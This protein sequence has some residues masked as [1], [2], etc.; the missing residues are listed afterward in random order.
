MR[1][2]IA[3]ITDKT[4]KRYFVEYTGEAFIQSTIRDL[5]RHLN[6]AK[7]HPQAYWFLDLESAEIKTELA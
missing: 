5:Q 2:A 7:Q 1:T 4:E 6:N 3:Y